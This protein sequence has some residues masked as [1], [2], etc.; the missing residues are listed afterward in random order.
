M[1]FETSVLILAWIAIA[2]LA[3][4]VS[5]LM[6]QVRRLS[7]SQRV[8]QLDSGPDLRDPARL[9]HEIDAVDGPQIILFLDNDCETC[10]RA[11][12]WGTETAN[13]DPRLGVVA[14]FRSDA[15]RTAAGTIRIEPNRADLFEALRI[16][17]TP[18]AV[19]IDHTGRVARSV[20]I[21]SDE[22]RRK[23]LSYVD[24]DREGLYATAP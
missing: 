8:I 13:A 22:A 20:A 24:R 7:S 9:E 4:A 5:G 3:F 12:D 6:A 23:L 11:L 18:Y 16:P 21:G 14:M 19:L 15:P 2:M 17:L 1:S 10:E